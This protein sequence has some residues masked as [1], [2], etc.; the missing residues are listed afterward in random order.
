MRERSFDLACFPMLMSAQVLVLNLVN[1]IYYFEYFFKIC[2]LIS[3][4][5]SNI[6]ERTYCTVQFKHP[7]SLTSVQK[8]RRRIKSSGVWRGR[9]IGRERTLQGLLARLRM[10]AFPSGK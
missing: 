1:Y 9:E 3:S 4:L 7:F 10:F 8:G 2:T 6:E 5:Q